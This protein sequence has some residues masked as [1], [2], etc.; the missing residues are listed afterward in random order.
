[1]SPK[2]RSPRQG[3]K[4]SPS[5]S[6]RR[7][8]KKPVRIPLTR[9]SLGAYGYTNVK[10]TVAVKRRAALRRAVVAEGPLPVFRKLNALSVLNKNRSPPTSAIFEADRDW[11]RRTFMK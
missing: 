3:R 4:R 1:M 10:E 2:R 9:G 6:P 7:S 5:R 11:V 8:P